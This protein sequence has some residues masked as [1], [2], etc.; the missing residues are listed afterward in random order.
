M[1]MIDKI[2][3]EG[4]VYMLLFSIWMIWSSR[5]SAWRTYFYVMLYSV[6]VVFLLTV[7]PLAYSTIQIIQ[8]W[9]LIIFWMFLIAFNILLINKDS[10]EFSKYCTSKLYGLVFA[11]IAAFLLGISLIFKYVI[12]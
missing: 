10:V 5:T 1:K 8:I 4:I 11:G 6:P 12:K 3:A 2:I 7:L 9:T